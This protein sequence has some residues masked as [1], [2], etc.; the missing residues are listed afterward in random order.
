[1]T[2]AS[3]L[4]SIAGWAQTND[5]LEAAIPARYG[6][7]SRRLTSSYELLGEDAASSKAFQSSLPSPYAASLSAFLSPLEHTVL[8]AHSMGGLIALEAALH[9]SDRV[10][11]LV[12]LNSTCC[13]VK[14]KENHSAES[15]PGVNRTTLRAMRFGMSTAPRLTLEQ[16]FSRA[17][18]QR[19]YA[20]K[21]TDYAQSLQTE[22]LIH[23]LEYLDSAD[24]SGKLSRISQPVLIIQSVND[25]IIPVESG[26]F[27][28][29]HLPNARLHLLEGEGHQVHQE[30]T[31]KLHPLIDD[32]LQQ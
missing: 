2:R 18:Q 7:L 23:G 19:S 26:R 17:Y 22:K 16:F 27:M 30:A 11:R 10:D 21:A 4:I 6:D 5:S 29:K 3:S 31:E 28:Q 12:L 9:F 8:F 32:F 15:I 14:K 13:F 20:V 1:M 24:L 25:R